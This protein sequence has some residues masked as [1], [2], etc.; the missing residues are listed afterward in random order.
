MLMF[1]VNITSD[2][3]KERKNTCANP[4]WENPYK[5]GWLTA[6]RPQAVTLL[7]HR[8][9]SPWNVE[10]WEENLIIGKCVDSGFFR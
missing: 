8:R 3:Y 5:R 1:F 2:E 4:R 10:G 7:T 6:A 9:H